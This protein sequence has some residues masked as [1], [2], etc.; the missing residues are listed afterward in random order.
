MDLSF[1]RFWTFALVFFAL[2][3]LSCESV[4]RGILTEMEI[5]EDQNQEVVALIPLYGGG[6]AVA[7]NRL[8]PSANLD[9]KE[10][11]CDRYS[12]VVMSE[13]GDLRWAY[14]GEGK[15]RVTAMAEAEPGTIALGGYRLD[16]GSEV[17]GFVEFVKEGSRRYSRTFSDGESEVTSV[18]AGLDGLWVGGRKGGHGFVS[19]FDLSALA[20]PSEWSLADFTDSK[21]NRPLE[22]NI[23]YLTQAPERGVYAIGFVKWA[24]GTR[25]T[26]IGRFRTAL[27]PPREDYW[28]GHLTS[29]DY[30]DDPG[31]IVLLGS[32]LTFSVRDPKDDAI[33]I[34]SANTGNLSAQPDKVADISSPEA[35]RLRLRSAIV[36]S[37]GGAVFVGA[38]GDFAKG[39]FQ[40]WAIRLGSDGRPDTS[41]ATGS[42]IGIRALPRDNKGFAFSVAVFRNVPMVSGWFVEG[43]GDA[44]KAIGFVRALR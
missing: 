8:C 15:G 42:S 22:S 31:P 1:I 19:R 40:P 34:Y 39:L 23:T 12:I 37:E 33:S 24:Q 28:T 17:H 26:W 41:W 35:S 5:R 30:D 4:T 21:G 18:V 27:E 10:V 32:S 7:I 6:V 38:R 25:N 14:S 11:L 2:Q 16:S 20:T 3:A 43:Q 44:E 9:H 36:D 29:K 13:E